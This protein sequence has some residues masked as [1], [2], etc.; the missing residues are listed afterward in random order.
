[1]EENKMKKLFSKEQ[2]RDFIKSNKFVDAES[3]ADALVAQYKDI[4][5]EALEAELDNKLGYSKYNWKNK[6]YHNSRNG[7]SKKTVQTKFG[8]MQL[9]IPRDTNSEFEPQ[10]VKKHERQINPSIDDRIISMYAKGISQRD[11]HAHMQEIYGLDI[12]ADMVSRITDKVIPLAKEWQNRPLLPIYAI[13]FLDGI[14]FN[15]RQNGQVVKKTT[16]V[17]SGI[18]I[19]GYKEILG[20]W[21]GEAESAKFWM[22]VMTDLEQRGVK[23]ILI[24]CIDGLNGFE[25]AISSVYPNTEIQKCIVHQIRTSTKFVS[26][27]D[28]KSFCAD[29]KL[30]YSATNEPEALS[31][32]DKFEEKWGKKYAYAVKSWRNNWSILATFFK[33]P[34]EIRKIIYTTNHIEGFNRV[35]RKVTKTK[36]SFST[37]DSLLKLLYLIIIDNTKKWTQP[38]PNWSAV[39]NQLIIFF[40][41]RITNYLE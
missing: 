2:A 14:V 15:V 8:K 24:A 7:H 4:L 41:E 11:I 13:V 5:Q 23:D 36:S 27:K 29:L 3:I 1:M 40:G 12:S 9:A 34:Q 32:L 17:V 35:I 18:T 26:Y 22:S 19:E 38:K 30:V 31:E 20:I 37:D 6:E 28:R 25:E 39:I 21:I 10:I 16:Y 33:Y